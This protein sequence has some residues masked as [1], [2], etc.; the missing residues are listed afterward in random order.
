MVMERVCLHDGQVVYILMILGTMD[1][2]DTSLCLFWLLMLHTFP[3]TIMMIT[4]ISLMPVADVVESGS[5]EWSTSWTDFTFKYSRWL[6]GT[7]I[8]RRGNVTG[9][10]FNHRKA[11]LLSHCPLV[12]VVEQK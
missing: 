11:L 10:R 3:T 4:I 2:F 1:S 12:V 7:K 9:S 6:S 5:F 8:T